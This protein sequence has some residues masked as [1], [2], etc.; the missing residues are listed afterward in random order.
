MTP[1]EVYER[2]VENTRQALSNAW[3]EGYRDGLSDGLDD[4]EGFYTN[5]YLKEEA[6]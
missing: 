5:P 6:S 4:S 1:E 2:R 3:D